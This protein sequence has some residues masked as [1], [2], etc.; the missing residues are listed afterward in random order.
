MVPYEHH[1][2][3]EGNE[4]KIRLL[5]GKIGG[6]IH[7]VLLSRFS[8]DSWITHILRA[9]LPKAVC[10]PCHTSHWEQVSINCFLMTSNM[11]KSLRDWGLFLGLGL[12]CGF[13][14][15]GRG[16]TIQWLGQSLIQVVDI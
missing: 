7:L 1:L 12:F 11:D 14:I 3:K 13:T 6:I 15:R 2:L 10:A 5:R 9:R 16:Q 8:S 4:T